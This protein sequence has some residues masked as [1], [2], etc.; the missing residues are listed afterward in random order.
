[1][2]GPLAVFARVP[3]GSHPDKVRTEL[4]IYALH[5][6]ASAGTIS[7]EL[8]DDLDDETTVVVWEVYRDAA[9]FQAHLDDPANA[10]FNA[11]LAEL[12][13]GAS[14]TVARLASYEVAPVPTGA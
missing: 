14:S 9:A 11:R 6:R 8:F 12:T 13:A 7:F 3:L 1:V 4:G 5:V 10:A 2:S